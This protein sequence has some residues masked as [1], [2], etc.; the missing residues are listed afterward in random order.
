MGVS[1]AKKVWEIGAKGVGVEAEGDVGYLDVV[2]FGLHDDLKDGIF[3]ADEDEFGFI[4]V[5]MNGTLLAL[6]F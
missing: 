2:E 4:W 5:G 1:P 3:I 6:G